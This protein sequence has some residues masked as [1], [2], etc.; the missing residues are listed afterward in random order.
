MIIAYLGGG[1]PRKLSDFFF[2]NLQIY[3]IISPRVPGVG[4]Q[5]CFGPNRPLGCRVMRKW[6][7]GPKQ[8]MT[9]LVT[10]ILRPL[11]AKIRAL[12]VLFGPV[13]VPYGSGM[14]YRASAT[15]MNK[16]LMCGV[17]HTGLITP[18]VCSYVP[19]MA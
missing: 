10:D 13:M 2:Q 4:N 1:Q 7:F 8:L 11:L 5:S 12:D 18:F 6:V 16:R 3:E 14:N 15:S 19:K 9:Q 17:A